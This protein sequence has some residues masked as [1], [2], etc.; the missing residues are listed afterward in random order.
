MSFV[1]DTFTDTGGTALS[2]HT[3]EAGATWAHQPGDGLGGTAL[4]TAAGT[5]RGTGADGGFYYASGSPA[6]ADYDVEAVLHRYSTYQGVH[7]VG[8]RM[9]TAAFTGYLFGYN[10]FAD[11]WQLRKFVGG[12]ETVL[13]TFAGSNTVGNDYTAKLELRGDQ[14]KGYVD[15]VEVC[16]ATDAAI[17]AAGKAGLVVYESGGDGTS[18]EFASLTATDAVAGPPHEYVWV[19]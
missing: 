6:S 9:D 8:G 1:T 4:I 17:S 16:A 19:P 13:D 18:W 15:G 14:V 3:G 11:V 7:Q 2:A 5:C 12:T 10:D